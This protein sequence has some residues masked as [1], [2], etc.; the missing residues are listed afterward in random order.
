MNLALHIVCTLCE[1]G[2]VCGTLLHL[3]S[4]RSTR[5][6]I[7]NVLDG[8]NIEREMALSFVSLLS[9]LVGLTVMLIGTSRAYQAFLK[10]CDKMHRATTRLSQIS[11]PT[12]KILGSAML[13]SASV[14]PEDRKSVV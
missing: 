6:S 4:L 9:A 10:T 11:T 7:G 14:V 8:T 5:R 12:S 3:F 2:I 1:V 13:N